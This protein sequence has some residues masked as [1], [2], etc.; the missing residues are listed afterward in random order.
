MRS[1]V[2]RRLGLPTVGLPV[3]PRAVDGLIEVLLN[4][5]GQHDVSL[6]FEHLCGW[7]GALFPSGF[8][9]LN[10]IRT[11]ELRGEE[12]LQVVSSSLGREQV[13][14]VAPPRQ[15]LESEVT[16]FLT[17][18]NTPT[19]DLDGL[20]RAGLA[21]LWFVTLHPFEDGNGRLARAITDMALAR[22]ERRPMRFYS[23]SAQILRE[24]DSYYTILENTSVVVWTSPT[25]WLGSSI[26]SKP[27]PTPLS[28]PLPT[29]WPK[30]AFG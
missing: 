7:Q 26:K 25:G 24:R 12:P 15:S 27:L 1:S 23:L 4:A 29:H 21:H 13:H 2:A 30:H 10:R 28:R 17:W 18:F 16:R 20:V 9:G 22:D 3:P 5:T 8:S 19:S 6:T 14:F 11:G